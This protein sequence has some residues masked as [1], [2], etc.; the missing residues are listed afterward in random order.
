[1]CAPLPLR[2][3]GGKKVQTNVFRLW[4]D[5]PEIF[6]GPVRFKR[7][8]NGLQFFIQRVLL[9]AS[10]LEGGFHIILHPHPRSYLSSRSLGHYRIDR[11]VCPIRFGRVYLVL[12]ATE[13]VYQL[14]SIAQEIVPLSDI[15]VLLQGQMVQPTHD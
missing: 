11:G 8:E 1:M 15:P 6:H 2:S 3:C 10:S 14:Q 7:T 13:F 4:G 5:H 9:R 12:L